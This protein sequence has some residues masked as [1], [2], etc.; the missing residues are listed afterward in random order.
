MRT[1]FTCLAVTA[2]GL[3]GCATQPGVVGGDAEVPHPH[4]GWWTA[5]LQTTPVM[6]FAAGWEMSCTDISGEFAF[7]VVDS[8][9]YVTLLGRDIEQPLDRRGRFVVRQPTE[10][11]VQES[12]SSDVALRSGAVTMIVKGDLRAKSRSG[13]LTQ[14]VQ[15]IG[16]GCKTPIVFI[17]DSELQARVE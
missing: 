1:F 11:A 12:P 7:E 6:Q 8:K 14:H 4:D 10:Y 3:A 16:G 2:L 17:R 13:S 9:V 5:H 15:E